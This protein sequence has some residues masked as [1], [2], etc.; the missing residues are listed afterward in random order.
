MSTVNNFVDWGGEFHTPP[1][2]ANNVV[3]ITPG[4]TTVW[5]V[6]NLS[7]ITPPLAPSSVGSGPS[8][9]VTGLGG[10][11][12]DPTTGY[13]WVYFVDGTE[14]TVGAAAYVLNGGESIAWDYKHFSSGFKQAP[15]P[16]F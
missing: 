13:Y 3:P 2:Q 15:H 9:Y 1:W 16:G 12:Q 10:V 6:L 5:D 7:A 11:D 4:A 8:L 14:P